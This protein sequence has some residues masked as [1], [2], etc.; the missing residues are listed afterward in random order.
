MKIHQLTVPDAL[1]SLKSGIEGL[2]EAEAARRLVEYGTN[3]V[4]EVAKQS[5]LLT[6][7]R[8][9]VHFFAIILWIAAGWRFLPSGVSLDNVWRRSGSR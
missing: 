5:L 7:A 4:E 3:E 6:F 8:E 9:F 2:S 1:A